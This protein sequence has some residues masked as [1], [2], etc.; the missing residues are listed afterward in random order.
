MNFGEYLKSLLKNRNLTQA[1][2]AKAIEMNTARLSRI[3]RGKE[4]HLPNSVTLERFC[5][6]LTTNRLERIELYRL[7]KK[8]PD[9]ILKAFTASAHTAEMLCRAASKLS[10][11][12][13]L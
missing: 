10:H 2:F 3:I 11:T 6:E 12:G 1:A 13:Y 8:T 7:A 5:A 9:E 4:K